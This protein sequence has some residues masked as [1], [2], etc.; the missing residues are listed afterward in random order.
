MKSLTKE[1]ERNKRCIVSNGAGEVLSEAFQA[2]S[3]ASSF[4]ENDDVLEEILSALT[5]MF[6][7][8]VQAKGFFGSASAMQCLIW[9]LR[10]G[11]LSR[12]RNAVL[13]LKELVSS[14]S[15]HNTTKVDELSETEGAIEALFKLIKDPICPSS[16]KA[17]LLII[18]QIITS[19][20]TK[21]KQVRNLVNLGA[22]SLL[23]ET[24]LDSERSI[25]EKALAVLDAISDTEEGRRMAIDNALSMPVWSRKSSEFPT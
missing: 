16:T 20:P 6:P 18:H 19:S 23:L 24:S 9:F 10:S 13:V 17:A 11:D 14:S 15:S 25:C 7:L 8:N 5:M 1:S 12:G 21:D 22:I 3:M 2:F 4:D